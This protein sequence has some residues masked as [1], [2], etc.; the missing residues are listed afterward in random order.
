MK[1]VGIVMLKIWLWRQKLFMHLGWGR[2]EFGV[3]GRLRQRFNTCTWMSVNQPN[4]P[5]NLGWPLT[6]YLILGNAWHF[7]AS[8][9]SSAKQVSSKDCCGDYIKAYMDKAQHSTR[10]IASLQPV[11]V[12]LLAV[13]SPALDPVYI[14]HHYDHTSPSKGED[15]WRAILGEDGGQRRL[16]SFHEKAWRISHLYMLWMRALH[17]LN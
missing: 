17:G 10:F 12:I 7:Q 11:S 16:S 1:F 15:Q 14:L 3:L 6:N 2:S 4:K 8:A 13:T 9:S 5:C